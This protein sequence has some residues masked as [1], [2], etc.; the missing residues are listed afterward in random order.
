MSKITVASMCSE[1][2]VQREKRQQLKYKINSVSMSSR[3]LQNKAAQMADTA[4]CIK[5]IKILM[6]QRLL[7]S[8]KSNYTLDKSLTHGYFRF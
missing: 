1:L 8:S 6:M 2:R 4:H 7:S 3:Q 5:L